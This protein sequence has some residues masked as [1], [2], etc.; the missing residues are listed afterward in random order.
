MELLNEKQAA[1]RL[2]CSVSALRRWRL[3]MKGP[4][5]VKLG[6]LVRYRQA[7]IEKFIEENA[8]RQTQVGA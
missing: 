6:R 8:Q 3:E 4:E 1:E 5:Y 7:G 2:N